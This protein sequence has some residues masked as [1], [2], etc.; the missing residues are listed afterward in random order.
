VLI[1]HSLFEQLHA[2]FQFAMENCF[3]TNSQASRLDFSPDNRYLS[4][5]FNNES[6]LLVFDL[7]DG[8]SAS[9]KGIFDATFHAEDSH[10]LTS[11][12]D[13]LQRFY[14]ESY[15]QLLKPPKQT[16]QD[17]NHESHEVVWHIYSSAGNMLA[18]EA[19]VCDVNGSARNESLELQFSLRPLANANVKLWE[20]T[21]DS[22]NTPTVHEVDYAKDLQDIRYIDFAGAGQS[23]IYLRVAERCNG[24]GQEFS[25]GTLD[26]ITGSKT[27]PFPGAELQYPLDTIH[28][29]RMSPT[30][31]SAIA[32]NKHCIYYW[33]LDGGW[34]GGKYDLGRPY[35]MEIVE[36]GSGDAICD[37]QYSR[38]YIAV[39]L[40][41]GTILILEHDSERRSSIRAGVENIFLKDAGADEGWF[42]EVLK[43]EVKIP[44]T[45]D[46]LLNPKLK[47][48]RTKLIAIAGRTHI[49]VKDIEQDIKNYNTVGRRWVLK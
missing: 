12:H 20:R 18:I 13:G 9:W 10:L 26:L 24:Q 47:C 36:H 48:A 19:I 1:T 17:K 8:N 27:L 40:T 3:K 14:G 43:F 23:T 39:G 11:S 6:T 35:E 49:L 30:G 31:D 4:A 42:K 22:T 34:T 2:L 46:R 44:N 45:N 25:L 32:A 41:S 7:T 33:W 15:E 5:V 21:F 29:V 37:V 28:L 16:R 38:D